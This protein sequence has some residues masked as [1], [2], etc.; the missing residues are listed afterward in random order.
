MYERDLAART[1]GLALQNGLAHVRTVVQHW[2]QGALDATVMGRSE[3]FIEI[4][5]WLISGLHRHES[6]I[7]AIGSVHKELIGVE[8]LLLTTSIMDQSDF[9]SN[10]GS[11]PGHPERPSPLPVLVKTSDVVPTVDLEGTEDALVFRGK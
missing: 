11:A 10:Q 9:V 1:V 5:V 2:P 7:T 4:R 8:Q 6:A 3:D